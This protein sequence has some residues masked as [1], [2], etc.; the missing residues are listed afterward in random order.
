ML[1]FFDQDFFE[2]GARGVVTE[3]ARVLEGG[4]Q[5][6]DSGEFEGHVIL[7]LRLD[8]GTDFDGADVGHVGRAI[9]E[10]NAGHELFRVDHLFD[11]LL[12]VMLSE[13]LVAPVLV[14]FG[15]QKV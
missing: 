4:I 11:G 1:F 14:H 8:V 13:A 10:E 7:D 5:V 15:V 2:E 6:R 9:E 3:F 12:T